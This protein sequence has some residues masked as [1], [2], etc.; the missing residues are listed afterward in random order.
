MADWLAA[1]ECIRGFGCIPPAAA[2]AGSYNLLCI[3]LTICRL[4]DEF[5]E[6]VAPPAAAAQGE[7]AGYSPGGVRLGGASPMLGPGP[8][9]R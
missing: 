2:A 1:N 7:A 4:Q 6:G 5:E 9:Y 3:S 8:V